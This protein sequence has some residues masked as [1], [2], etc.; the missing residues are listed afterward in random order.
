LSETQSSTITG[1]EDV[2]ATVPKPTNTTSTSSSSSTNS[3]I[4]NS[5]SSRNSSNSGFDSME[6]AAMVLG[7]LVGGMPNPWILPKFMF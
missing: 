1:N 4:T 5:A 2:G 7:L 3:S 6:A